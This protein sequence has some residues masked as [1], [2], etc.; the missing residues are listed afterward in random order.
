MA[1]SLQPGSSPRPPRRGTRIYHPISSY[2]PF[3]IFLL[4]LIVV[5]LVI[6]MLVG[7]LLSA[8]PA[9][10]GQSGTPTSTPTSHIATAPQPP[11]T[12]IRPSQTGT[13]TAPTVVFSRGIDPRG[14]PVG[15][16]TSFAATQPRV[17]AFVTLTNIPAAAEVRFVWTYGRPTAIT[18]ADV[19]EHR[20][21]P[22]YAAYT[23]VSY[24][25]PNGPSFI[26]GSY[27]V[28][29]TLAGAPVALGHFRIVSP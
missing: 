12:P 9:S 7:R 11:A 1:P 20:N 28:S 14:L 21:G 15:P 26:T 10:T 8:F 4:T 5:V 24:A 27:T 29:V 3:F 16:A 2:V 25:T 22:A 19:R 6:V 23:F 17:Y 18:L 13:P